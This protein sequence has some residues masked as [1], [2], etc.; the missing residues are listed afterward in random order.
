MAIT[1]PTAAKVFKSTSAPIAC[2]PTADGKVAVAARYDD[3][4]AWQDISQKVTAA[5]TVAADGKT[6]MREV[7]IPWAVITAT[8]K[9]PRDDK[10]EMGVDFAW[11]A[12]PP[13]FVTNVKN[14][15]VA[16]QD[17]VPGIWASF[18]T[19]KPESVTAG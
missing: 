16:N 14:C 9:L 2:W 4:T 18:L 19:A 11:N 1:S 8:G 12:V 10:V 17:A 6:A 13:A 3:E 15:L 5:G 7:R